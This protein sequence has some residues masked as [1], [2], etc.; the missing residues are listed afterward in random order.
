M[1][2]FRV[3]LASMLMIVLAYTGVVIATH[4]LGLLPVFF[5]D[6]QAMNWPGQFNLDFSCLLV[7]SGL[8]LAWRHR[9]SPAGIAL[10][11]LATIGGTPVLAGYLLIASVQAK[12]DARAL[13]LG[14]GRIAP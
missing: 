7:L 12:G 3:L 5:S 14:M 10:G 6:I 9:F 13:L 1:T 8:W 4:G 2:A 11:G